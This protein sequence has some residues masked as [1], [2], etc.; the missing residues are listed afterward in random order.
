MERGTETRI[1]NNEG[2]MEWG[3]MWTKDGRDLIFGEF[4]SGVTI[5]SFNSWRVPADGSGDPVQVTR[6]APSCLD[7]LA[8]AL[9]VTRPVGPDS[10]GLNSDIETEI[11]RVSLDGSGSEEP[12][13]QSSDVTAF[14]GPISPDGGLIAYISRA[15]A[16]R[17]SS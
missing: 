8:D 14:G 10:M 7:L 3:M 11:V 2:R 6:G 13:L 4:F 16:G 9:I 17:R 15:P 1:T 5:G 12:V